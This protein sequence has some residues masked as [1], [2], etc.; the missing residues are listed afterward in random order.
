MHPNN[1]T[2]TELICYVIYT[3][4]Q[5]KLTH[6]RRSYLNETKFSRDNIQSK[7]IIKMLNDQHLLFRRYSYP[8]CKLLSG[9]ELIDEIHPFP[10]GFFAKFSQIVKLDW[11]NPGII[12]G[13]D[14]KHAVLKSNLVIQLKRKVFDEHK[15]NQQKC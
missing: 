8:L 14:P 13:E 11:I 6:Q 4:R 9:L 5:K 3:L 15:N 10:I 12:C 1:F 2:H 7:E